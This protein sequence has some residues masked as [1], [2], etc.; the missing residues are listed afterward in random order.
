VVPPAVR[1]LTLIVPAQDAGVLT[2]SL[3][4]V[5]R[6]STLACSAPNLTAV[7]N[8]RLLPETVTT[9]APVTG[10][11]W[12]DK[13]VS[14]GRRRKWKR[15]VDGGLVPALAVTRIAAAPA[16]CL[17]VTTVSTCDDCTRKERA[18]FPP[19]VTDRT[20]KNRAPRMVTL[21]PP[22]TGPATGDTE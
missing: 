12:A 16:A 10:P 18:A 21:V 1:T 7:T 6:G 13:P 9:C 14:R 20:W 4:L 22:P 5:E 2:R 15:A 11:A 19:I 17:G 3:V 8:D